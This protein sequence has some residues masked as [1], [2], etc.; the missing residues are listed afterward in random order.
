MQHLQNGKEVE[1]IRKPECK[2]DETQH[3]QLT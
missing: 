3:F 2:E 1:R